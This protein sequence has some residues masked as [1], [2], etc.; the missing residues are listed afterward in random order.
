MSD[1]FDALL[2]DAGTGNLHSVHNALLSLGYAIRITNRPEDL[3]QP[4][5]VILP[6]VGA[7]ARFMD[8]LRAAG[9]AEPLRTAVLRGD[10]MLGICVGMQALFEVG[11]EMGQHPGL[12][13]L[14]GKVVHFPPLGDLKVPHTGWNQILYEGSPPCLRTFLLALTLTLTIP[15]TALPLKRAMCWPAPIMGFN[16]PARCSV[17]LYRPSNSTL[18]KANR[19]DYVYWKILCECI[20]SQK[21]QN[22]SIYCFSS[23]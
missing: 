6:G 21:G 23:H 19:W 8:G 1:K 20:N 3:A 17:V 15:T 16:F 22:V 14:P 11:E 12:G 9:L 13:L 7:F 2:I 5:R 10:P 18:R 4:A